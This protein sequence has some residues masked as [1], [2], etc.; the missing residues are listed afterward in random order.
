M[1]ASPGAYGA[2]RGQMTLR[3]VLAAL[4]AITVPITVALPH[5]DQAFDENG[6]LKD[7]KV[8]ASVER[9]CGEL[10]RLATAMKGSS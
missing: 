4:A 3:Q 2:V 8:R 9:A 5:A 1:G 7:P 10:L 6:A